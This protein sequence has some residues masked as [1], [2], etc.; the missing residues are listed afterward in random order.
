MPGHN[1]WFQL[2][3]DPLDITF[4][5]YPFKELSIDEAAD[6]TVK[7]IA[8]K[9]DNLY[10]GLSGG[11]DS[12]FVANAL[13]RNKIPFTP[14]IFKDYYT[15]EVDY[16]IHFCR[17]NKL[18]PVIIEKNM[19]DDYFVKILTKVTN[20]LP[21]KDCFSAINVILGSIVKK[22]NGHLIIGSGVTTCD[23]PYPEPTGNM[24]EFNIADFY[25]DIVFN[26]QHPSAFF[27]YTPEIF[28]AFQK[29]INVNL[30]IQE[31]KAV[32]YNLN[33]RPKIKPYHLILVDLDLPKRTE[34]YFEK[35][36]FADILEQFEPF[37]I[38]DSALS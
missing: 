18:D 20:T 34:C 2:S 23:P 11:Y 9:Y 17:Q 32:L 30:P 37:V 27:T 29:N 10:L 8:E 12:E 16:A 6:Y 31:A 24:T 7:V 25:L 36:T 4:N 35:G 1:N 13:L 15:R 33:F 19:M 14:I 28:Y 26:D 22:N 21:G 3:I 38:K 5:L